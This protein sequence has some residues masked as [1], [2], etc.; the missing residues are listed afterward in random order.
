MKRKEKTGYEYYKAL[1]A[2]FDTEYHPRLYF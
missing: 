1:K 2:K